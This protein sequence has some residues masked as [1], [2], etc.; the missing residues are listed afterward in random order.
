[1]GKGRPIEVP[2][3]VEALNLLIQGGTEKERSNYLGVY[4]LA[5]YNAGIPLPQEFLEA[6]SDSDKLVV[7][8][9]AFVTRRNKANQDLIQ[10][11]NYTFEQLKVDELEMALRSIRGLLLDGQTVTD[12]GFCC[13]K[14]GKV[15]EGCDF[16]PKSG[17]EIAKYQSIEYRNKKTREKISQKAYNQP[18]IKKD[19]YEPLRF[20][21]LTTRDGDMSRV[22]Q[23]D[24]LWL[25]KG[26]AKDIEH[27]PTMIQRYISEVGAAHAGDPQGGRFFD[28]RDTIAEEMSKIP[29]P[30]YAKG[31]TLERSVANGMVKGWWH[32]QIAILLTLCNDTDDGELVAA[33]DDDLDRWLNMIEIFSNTKA[34]ITLPNEEL[35]L[36]RDAAG[37]SLPGMANGN[38]VKDGAT[39]EQQKEYL[40][41]MG[42]ELLIRLHHAFGNREDVRTNPVIKKLGKLFYSIICDR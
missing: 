32:A 33:V 15:A 7:I 17:A 19:D 8:R 9:D 12:A 29:S 25:K 3:V 13:D 41:Y 11:I 34:T 42:E 6:K 40:R 5:L 20:M 38:Q 16:K 26:I 1:M 37:N 14:N 35:K 10:S 4:K 2:E 21:M 31:K 18:D 24:Y 39:L 28:Y 23:D 36:Y 30:E 27:F 22:Y